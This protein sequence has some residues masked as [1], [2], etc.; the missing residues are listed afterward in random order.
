MVIR[1]KPKV[2]NMLLALF[3]INLLGCSTYEKCGA[4]NVA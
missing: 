3:Q 1:F 4:Y 2:R